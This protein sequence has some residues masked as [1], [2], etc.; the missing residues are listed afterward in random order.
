MRDGRA[1]HTIE[2]D[3]GIRSDEEGGNPITE[4]T[5]E[6]PPLEEVNQVIPLRESKALWMS[7]LRRRLGFLFLCNLV[8]MFLT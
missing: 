8:A 7:S 5:R 4:S 3:P 6:A 1:G 2:K